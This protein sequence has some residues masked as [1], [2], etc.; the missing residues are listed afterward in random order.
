MKAIGFDLGRTLI[1]YKDISLSWQSLYKSAL[2]DVLQ[3]C[4]CCYDGNKI[5]TGEEILT[6]YNTR[7]NAREYEITSDVIDGYDLNENG[8]YGYKYLDSYWEEDERYPFIITVDEKLAGFALVN[9]HAVTT[10]TDYTIAEFFIC[11]KYRKKGV[12][13]FAAFEIFN[14]FRGTWEVRELPGN[15]PAHKFWRKVIKEYTENNY[16]ELIVGANGWEGPIQR[17]CNIKQT[18]LK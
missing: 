15:I 6:K 2:S 7:I 18:E 13:Q 5:K 1:S 16:E 9:K 14:K 3:A 8:L 4:G 10:P 17:F 12:G 11:K